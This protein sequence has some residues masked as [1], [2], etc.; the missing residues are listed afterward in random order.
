MITATTMCVV[1][2]T[3][4][5]FDSTTRAPSHPSKEINASAAIDASI[6]VRSHFLRRIEIA[7]ITIDEIPSSTP[8][9]RLPYSVHV[10]A[11]LKTA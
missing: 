11:A 10:C 9:R 7:T 3:G 6:A 1:I 5:S 2:F 4:A 8:L